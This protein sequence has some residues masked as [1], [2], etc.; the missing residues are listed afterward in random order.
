MLTP[1]TI[2]TVKATAPVLAEH[3]YAIIQRFYQRLFQAHPELKNIFN[4]RH[5]ERG[6][7]QRA[8]A[9]GGAG[10]CHAYRQPVGAGPGGRTDHAQARESERAACAVPGGGRASAGAR[11]RRFSASA[12]TGDILAAWA[13]AYQ[14]LAD[15]MIAAEEALYARRQRAPA[16]GGAGATSW[17]G[18]SGRRAKS[19]PP[20]FWS[21][22]TAS[23]SPTSSP[24]ST[25]AS[26]ST[27]R[28]WA[29]SRCA[30]TACRMRQTASSYRI[31][32]KRESEGEPETAGYVS[33]LLHDYVNPGDVVRITPPFGPIPCRHGRHHAGGADQRGRGPDA[34][35]QHAEGGAE[36]HG[37]RGRVRARRAQRCACTP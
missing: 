36:E 1:S 14:A 9:G 19:S 26:W 13:E 2:A 8:L 23:R 28:A 32:V 33:N 11:S 17:Y 31:S 4:M 21:P 15:I 37:S 35:G 7:Q 12:A 29:C 30:S 6:E 25:S 16:A 18:T 22:K 3:G 24:A 27:C 34:A 20:S 5:Q 10:L